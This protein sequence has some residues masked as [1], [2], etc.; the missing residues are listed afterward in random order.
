MRIV[1]QRVREASVTVV[2]Q[3]K[4]LEDAN[5]EREVGRIGAGLCVLV[6]I[7]HEDSAVQVEKVVRKICELKLLRDEK[8]DDNPTNRRSVEEIGGSVL[9]VS[10]FTLY[11][12]VKKGKKPS[13]SKAAPG[14]VAAP[15]FEQVVAGV[16]ARGINVETG[17]FGA[18][19]NVKIV[20]DGP[21]TIIFEC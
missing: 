1:I 6:G 7:T 3:E 8:G 20:N 18:M 9:L 4:S 21:F 17:E 12:D 15:I 16:R 19:M 13:W 10:Q 11:A 14:E 5:L 2:D